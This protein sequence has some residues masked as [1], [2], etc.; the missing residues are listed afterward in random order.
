[1]LPW[2]ICYFASRHAWQHLAFDRRLR[3]AADASAREAW[4]RLPI[5][6]VCTTSSAADDRKQDHD[7]DILMAIAQSLRKWAPA[8]TADATHRA[9]THELLEHYVG[10]LESHVNAMTSQSAI[11]Y[12]WVS[13]D[14]WEGG[15]GGSW[16]RGAKC[17]SHFNALFIVW[18]LAYSFQL[19]STQTSIMAPTGAISTALRLDLKL[20]PPVAQAVL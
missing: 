5:G 4:R 3:V 12:A 7:R 9:E 10:Y 6:A 15:R 16:S 14:F 20:L 18:T 19:R 8:I 1:M 13:H 2:P 11:D 17:H